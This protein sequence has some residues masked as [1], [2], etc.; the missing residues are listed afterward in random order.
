METS[1]EKNAREA[2]N[3]YIRKWRKA[4]PD[5]VREINRRYWERRGAR[6]AALRKESEGS[7]AN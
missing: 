2:R 3:E 5:K 6:E 7:N 1:V 4:N